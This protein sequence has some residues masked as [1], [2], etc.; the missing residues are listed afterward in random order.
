MEKKN[1]S[2]GL[3][4]D[5]YKGKVAKSKRPKVINEDER[6]ITEFSHVVKGNN[7]NKWF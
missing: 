6:D 7:K 3:S 5:L 2:G 4:K 1:K